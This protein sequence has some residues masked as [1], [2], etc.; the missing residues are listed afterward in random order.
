MDINN[1]STDEKKSQ[2]NFA[3]TLPFVVGIGASAGGLSS[4]EGV[5]RAIPHDASAAFVIIQHISPDTISSMAEILSR[6]TSISIGTIEH[7]AQ[8]E[9]NKIYLIGPGEEVRLEGTKFKTNPLDRTSVTKVIDKFFKSLA[10]SFGKK[11]IGVVL[12]GSGSDGRKGVEAIHKAGG[13]CIVESY[14][15]A[16]FESMPKS[17]F[18]SGFVSHMLAP[19]EIG[20]WLTQ[21]LGNPAIR[22]VPKVNLNPDLLTGVDLI[23]SQLTRRHDVDFS[24]YKASTIARRIERRQQI[25]KRKSILDYA[26]FA[27][28]S[29]QELDLLYHDLLIGVTK[30]FRDSDAFDV[31]ERCLIELI[32]NLPHKETLR[33]WCA[34][35]ASGEEA[36]SLAMLIND[37]F[38]NANRAPNYKIFATDIHKGMLDFASSGRYSAEAMEFVTDERKERYFTLEPDSY[39]HVTSELRR[40]LVF[41]RQ[42]VFK[43]PPFTRM[44]LVTCRNLLIYL[45]TNAQLHAI[46]SFHFSLNID[47]VLFLGA[48]ESLGYLSDEFRIIDSD[49]RI[50]QKIKNSPSLTSSNFKGDSNTQNGPRRLANIL[51]SDPPETMSFTRLVECY[52]LILAEYIS[53]GLLLDEQRNILH[54]FGDANQ[55]LVSKTG[56][57]SGKLSDFISGD[58]Q[59]SIMA[60]LIRA[61]KQIGQAIYLEDVEIQSKTEALVTDVEVLALSGS[62]AGSWIW[63]VKFHGKTEDRPSKKKTI[64]VRESGDAISE[65]ES[66]LIYTKD[67]LNATIEE[68]EASNEELQA[69][70]EELVASNEE[71]QSTNEELQSVNEE[72]YTVN[73]ENNRKIDEL[74]ELTDDLEVLLNTSEVGTLFLDTKLMIRKFT[75]S[76]TRHFDLMSH[77]IG[78]PITN[79]SNRLGIGELEKK[80][81]TVLETEQ[82]YE[83][84]LVDTFGTP[85]LLKID[86]HRS[87]DR[88][89]GVILNIIRRSPQAS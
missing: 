43:D 3:D 68:L 21:Q 56:R 74:Q 55:Y 24:Q 34:G 35:C 58:A 31:L 44:H 8:I 69:A 32:H 18:D 6:S 38:E 37:A 54:V 78:R 47:A 76:I 85:I 81:T 1:I 82:P 46:S 42:N 61:S 88:M 67:S 51:I 5:L 64:S 65:I 62:K 2:A 49:W 48:S 63:C 28:D 53:S 4:I 23:F 52:D 89:T 25:T 50:F 75:Q 27:R 10:N 13:I 11:A 70:N 29:I 45:K 77:D 66:E 39:Y 84:E 7:D 87:S 33:V 80:L 83:L 17:C 40:H 22:P 20:Q 41:A 79:F 14:E 15:T 72:L 73:L 57:F 16:Q 60:A 19:D 86:V 36:Y 59:V 71:L 9:P 30:F 26:E 12:S